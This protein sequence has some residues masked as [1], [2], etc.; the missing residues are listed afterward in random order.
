MR[1]VYV[2]MC[3]QV[4]MCAHAH[5]RR[6]LI[7]L[8]AA[9][10]SYAKNR[11][12]FALS[13]DL[14][15][16][17]DSAAPHAQRMYVG[18]W[19]TPS[20]AELRERVQ[21][22]GEGRDAGAGAPG[23]RF[24]HLADPVGVQSL[25]A[26]PQNADAVFQAA[27]QFN[28]LE[29]VGPGVSPRQGITCYVS[30]PTQGPKCALA[31]PA[32][33]VFRNYLCGKDFE[34]QGQVQIDC[35]ADVGRVLGNTNGRIWEM[36][37]GYCLPTAPAAMRELN[38]A[39]S[40]TLSCRFSRTLALHILA[41]RALALGPAGP[42]VGP[43]GPRELSH[44]RN[45][46]NGHSDL[47]NPPLSLFS[48]LL[49]RPPAL[50]LFLKWTQRLKNNAQL[51]QAAVAALRVGVHW[52]TSVSRARARALSISLYPS[53]SLSLYPSLMYVCPPML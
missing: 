48:R 49:A 35:L 42:G 18:P 28:C 6:Q 11:A 16:L 32:G 26:D 52:D 7:R 24:Q 17:C 40:D 13:P 38:Q 41:L 12:R 1:C 4:R 53:L 39:S 21:A 34:G 44:A 43:G 10:A 20:V 47:R 3:M 9:T 23:L 46:S 45:P 36:Q 2:G 27:S 15:L 5:C 22:A 8:R 19:E 50:F 14:Y 25:I 29:M 37:N 30:D 51:Y 33:T 31:C